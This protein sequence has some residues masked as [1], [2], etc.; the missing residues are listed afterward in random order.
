[1]CVP[2]PMSHVH[3]AF[4]LIPNIWCFTYNLWHITYDRCILTITNNRSDAIWRQCWA[5]MH[6]GI[7]WLRTNII[8]FFGKFII[9]WNAV[10]YQNYFNAKRSKA[11]E[12][13]SYFL[14]FCWLNENKKTRCK[15]IPPNSWMNECYHGI[16]DSTVWWRKLG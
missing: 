12:S 9:I 1:M 4:R 11:T 15:K 13:D 3:Y 6:S 5:Q 7:R 8:L 14:F 16:V 2:Y 10:K